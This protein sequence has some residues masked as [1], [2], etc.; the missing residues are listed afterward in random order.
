MSDRKRKKAGARSAPTV[1]TTSKIVNKNPGC[2]PLKEAYAR[3]VALHPKSWDDV[4][5]IFLRGMEGFDA[6][7]ASGVATTGDLQNGKGDFFN[8]LLALVLENCAQVQLFSR[9][10]VPGLFIPKHNLDVTYPNEGPIEFILEAKAVGTPR[11]PL[12]QKAKAM[13]R[14]GS[15]DL[16]K[17]IKE[18]GFKAID[19]KLE[20]ARTA[21]A[22]GGGAAT[23]TGDLATWLRAVKPKSFVCFAARVV[24][25]TDLDAV[26][27]KAN[28]A[29]SVSD[30]VGL[31]CYRPVAADQPTRYVA[32]HVPA[33]LEL[34]RMLFRACQDLTAIKTGRGP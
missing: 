1:R 3:A 10:S 6:N 21:G 26:L 7:V 14:R 19:L 20:F 16:D 27:G 11:H 18:I 28:L 24:N 31:F 29:A 5:D 9:L 15:A 23:V 22:Q 34:G 25:K 12:S 30:A 13:G 17:R 8:D 4:Q 33:H 2:A 32:E